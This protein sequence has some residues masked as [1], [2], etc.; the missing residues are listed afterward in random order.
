MSTFSQRPFRLRPPRLFHPALAVLALALSGLPAAATP[1]GQPTGLTVVT[2]GVNSFR[3]T[4]NDNSTDETFFGVQARVAG[5]TDWISLDQVAA[6]SGGQVSHTLIIGVELTNTV[7]QFQILAVKDGTPQEISGTEVFTAVATPSTVTFVAPTGLTGTATDGTITLNWNDNANSEWGYQV[8]N[9]EGTNTTWTALGTTGPNQTTSLTISS[10]RPNTVY[11]YRVRA[12]KNNNA[13]LTL[14]SNTFTISTQPLIAPTNLAATR[15]NERDIAFTQTDNS[16]GETGYL[17]EYRVVGTTEWS[18]LGTVGANVSSINAITDLF[19]PATSYEFRTTA[20]FGEASAPEQFSDPSNVATAQTLFTAPTGLTASPTSNTAVQL[21]WADNSSVEQGYGVYFRSAGSTNFVLHGFTAAN[22]VAYSVTGLEGGSSYEFQ[23]ASAYQANAPTNRTGIVYSDPSGIASATTRDEMN[24]AVYVEA[25]L[26]RPFSHTLTATTNTAISAS[27]V[28]GLPSGLEYIATNHTLSGTASE[29]GVFECPVTL[30]FADGWTQ[31]TTL[32]V[33]VL[34]PP[35]AGAVIADRTLAPS[36]TASIPL[37][38]HFSDPDAE[39]AVRVATNIGNMDF[40][41]F[42]SVTPLTVSNFMAYAS[43]G[44]YVDTVFH[45]SVPGFVVQGGAFRPDPGTGPA[46]YVSVPTRP[47]VPNEPGLSSVRATISMAK[48]GSES[49]GGG[50][51]SATNQFFINLMN[52]GPILNNQNGGFTVFGRVTLPGMVVADQMA[53]LPRGTFNITLNG[54]PGSF[55]DWPL[56]AA[57][58]S[59]DNS[60][61]VKMSGVTSIPVLVYSV[62]TNT[63]ASVVA[64]A[65]NGGALELQALHGGESLITVRATDLDG[66]WV[67]Q[68]F[69]VSVPLSFADWIAGQSPPPGQEGAHLDAD[70]GGLD[71]LAEFAYMGS[72]TNTLDDVAVKPVFALDATNHV[73]S[74]EFNMRKGTVLQYTVRSAS[75]L[76]PA[77]WAVVWN[78]S[79]NATSEAHVTVLENEPT[80]LRIRVRDTLSPASPERRHLSVDVRE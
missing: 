70:A 44:D 47:Q 11:Q 57:S 50:P 18:V 5:N 24:S 49:P 65:I 38:G 63:A 7:L 76:S 45:R 54:T 48:L 78:S 67:E 29:A 31:N 30:E 33:R 13:N 51:D 22:A 53:A 46:A 34:R 1:P 19:D 74:A 56:T 75:E 3:L 9:K 69:T 42:N 71:N 26:G 41:L 25:V 21:G 23:V 15:S 77:D 60:L 14:Y 58:Q 55:E 36:G 20:F 52:N 17:I 64:A 10:H 12:T 43:A 27:S 4:W 37:S 79:T 2:L 32:T 62:A 66:N 39:S 61:A 16:S 72:A 73:L 6:A 28:T 68:S 40:I 59:M 80:H 8:E 35:L